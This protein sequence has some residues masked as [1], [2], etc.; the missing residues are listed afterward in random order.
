MRALIRRVLP[1]SPD[2]T[3][4]DVGCG[5]GGNI[6]ALTQDYP[7]IG[8]DESAE[9]I[10]LARARF[11]KVPFICG[12]VPHD[13]VDV[14]GQVGLFLL[15]DVLEHVDDDFLALSQLLSMAKPGSYLLLTV[16]ADMGLWS[17]HDV[18][19][20]HY[21]RY[22][23]D[24]LRRVWSGLPVQTCLV[25]YYNSRLYPMVKAMRALSR[26]RGHAD[27][28]AGTDFRVP[29][30][31]LNRLLEETFAGEAR[32]LLAALEGNRARGFSRGVSLI[33]LLRREPGEICPRRR[34]LDLSPDPHDPCLPPPS[35]EGGRGEATLKSGHPPLDAP[36]SRGKG[37]GLSPHRRGEGRQVGRVRGYRGFMK[38]VRSTFARVV[39]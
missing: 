30:R 31:P 34:P 38:G 18:S 24:R 36:P 22:D 23:L 7:C 1:A 17:E 32:V 14:K 9:A 10:R 27:G 8:I 28:I 2:K 20:G 35:T 19:F 25:S 3:V 33:A 5:T 13:W 26:L 15:M 6:A 16:P 4:V 29:I 21:R 11:P 37:N 12:A 39:E